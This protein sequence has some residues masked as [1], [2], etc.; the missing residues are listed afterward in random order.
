MP[1]CCM[2]CY[3]LFID[4]WSGPATSFELSL[5][6]FLRGQFA[7]SKSA[8]SASACQALLGDLC[9]IHCHTNLLLSLRLSVNSLHITKRINCINCNSKGPLRCQTSVKKPK[10]SRCTKFTLQ[11]VL[12]TA[13]CVFTTIYIYYRLSSSHCKVN[14]YSHLGIM[15][16]L[17]AP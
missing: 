16:D 12:P 9:V 17:K 1:P 7:N 5:N 3:K 10:C 11:S 6:Y 13:K 14:S 4:T 15:P 8:I 2:Q